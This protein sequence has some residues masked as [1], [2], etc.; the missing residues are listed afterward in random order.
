MHCAHLAVNI[1]GFLKIMSKKRQTL[2]Y[3]VQNYKWS[4]SKSCFYLD[5]IKVWVVEVPQEP[6]HAR[7]QNL[8]K[9]FICHY[10]VKLIY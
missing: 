4:K 10:F 6:Q 2:H 1:Y 8:N 3:A 5:G 7:P 9:G